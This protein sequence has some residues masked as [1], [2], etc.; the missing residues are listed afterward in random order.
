M[1]KSSVII[2]IITFVLSVV[3]VGVFGMKMISYNT[4]DYI[5]TITPTAVTTSANISGVELAGGQEE[6]SYILVLPYS[7]GL[8][9]RIDYE[10]DPAD[11]TDGTVELTV[12]D[13]ADREVVEIDGLNLHTL[14]EGSAR[15]KYRA[16]DGGGA[17]IDVTLYLLD[18]DYYYSLA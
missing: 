14:K 2:V 13:P 3:L 4:R 15:L 10:I 9:I 16:K 7:E 1:K 12:P 6:N 5:K 18:P 11:A 8:I 17:E